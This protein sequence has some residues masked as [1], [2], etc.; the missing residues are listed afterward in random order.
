MEDAITSSGMSV[1]PLGRVRHLAAAQR[2]KWDDED[3]QRHKA[4]REGINHPVQSFA[5]D[6]LLMSMVRV[7]EVLPEEAWIVAEVHDEI[8]LLVAPYAVRQVGMMVKETMEDVSWLQKFG[9]KL[10]VPVLAEVTAGPSWG[11]QKEITWTQT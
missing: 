9:I 1:S 6:L 11:E 4:I 2:P 5:S 3:G 7:S 10:T 8:D